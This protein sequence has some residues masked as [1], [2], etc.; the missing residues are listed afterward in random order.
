MLCLSHLEA[1]ALYGQPQAPTENLSFPDLAGAGCSWSAGVGVAQAR[2]LSFQSQHRGKHSHRVLWEH[3][4][5]NLIVPWG[6][7]EAFPER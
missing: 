2:L 6:S 4:E 3:E 1:G 7:Q 5:G